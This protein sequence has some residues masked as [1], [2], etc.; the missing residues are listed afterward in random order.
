MQAEERAYFFMSCLKAVSLKGWIG[1]DKADLYNW[2]DIQPDILSVTCVEISIISGLN[3]IGYIARVAGNWGLNIIDI[4]IVNVAELINEAILNKYGIGGIIVV[5]KEQ[6][7]IGIDLILSPDEEYPLNISSVLNPKIK[8]GISDCP[9]QGDLAPI[10]DNSAA[11]ALAHV[12]YGKDEQ[13]DRVLE[14][15]SVHWGGVI[16][17]ICLMHGLFVVV[18]DVF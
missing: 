4:I 13:D 9:C 8:L 16:G 2:V 11:V 7:G 12:K 5:N 18:L 15:G 10:D 14:G 1:A 17:C 6:I 3:S